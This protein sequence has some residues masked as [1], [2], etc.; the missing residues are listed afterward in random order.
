MVELYLHSSIAASL[1]AT[2]SSFD[3]NAAGDDGGVMYASFSSN[4]TMDE[5]S[6]DNNVVAR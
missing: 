4:I 6:F 1:W 5:S 3:N 2:A